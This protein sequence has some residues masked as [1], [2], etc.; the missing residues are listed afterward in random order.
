VPGTPDIPASGAGFA[1]VADIARRRAQGWLTFGQM[2]TAPTP[3]WVVELRSGAV[4]QRLQDA[5][6]WR[7]GEVADFGPSMLTLGVYDRAAHRRT[8]AHDF[9][10]LTAAYAELADADLLDAAHGACELLRQLSADES[11]AWSSG[12]LP[13]ARELRVH[14]D[15]ELRGATGDRLQQT[16]AAILGGTPR[17]PYAALGQLCQLWVAMERAGSSFAEGS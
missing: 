1:A 6:G 4:R 8:V 5:V 3:A 13:R 11:M 9:K 15:R 17:P 14:Q 12:S 2:F 16:C 10:S 7:T